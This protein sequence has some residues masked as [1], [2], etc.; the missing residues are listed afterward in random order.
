MKTT[1]ASYV[2][3]TALQS[4]ADYWASKIRDNYGMDSEFGP[5]VYDG[6]I[7]LREVFNILK[8][9]PPALIK[10]C[11]IKNL[12]IRG[13]MGLSK[14]YYPNHGYFIGDQIALNADIFHHPDLPDDFF[15][16][17]GYFLTRPQQTLLHE[18]SHAFDF[19]NGELSRKEDW[20]KLSGWSDNFK[21]GLKRLI[22]NDTG[23]PQIIGDM[24]YNP[25]AEGFTR[26]YARRNSEED[27]A[28]SSAF[29]IGRLK[30]K[31]PIKKHAYFDKI[32]K[33]YYS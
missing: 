19:C 2:R 33:K 14:P 11:G 20:F 31:V 13:N 25:K 29:Y 27:W 8:P 10:D 17:H 21:P 24:Y 18:F 9:V 3:K 32:Y 23:T 4:K 6:H 30:D 16:H 7:I 1:I 15:D 5:G 28:D 22:I 26:F 12:L